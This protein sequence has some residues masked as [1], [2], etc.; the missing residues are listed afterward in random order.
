MWDWDELDQREEKIGY[1]IREALQDNKIPY[2]LV[3]GDK[4]IE[5]NKAAIRIRGIGES[6]TLSVDEFLHK[7]LEKIQTKTQDLT[8]I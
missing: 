6:G 7:A 8:L 5:Q 2:V 4:E 3:V 1:K